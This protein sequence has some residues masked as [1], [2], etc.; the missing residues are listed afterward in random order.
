MVRENRSND[1][2]RRGLWLVDGILARLVTWRRLVLALTGFAAGAVFGAI[3]QDL[4]NSDMRLLDAAVGVLCL[5]I[6]ALVTVLSE[7]SKASRTSHADVIDRLE[8][9]GRYFNLRV[10][11]QM[12]KD[13]NNYHSPDQDLVVQAFRAAKREILVLD[14]LTDEGVRPDIDMNPAVMKWHLDTIEARAREGVAYRRYCQVTDTSKPFH[15]I[16][17]RATTSGGNEH[18]FAD[19][20]IAMCEMRSAA[21]GSVI[22]KVAPHIYP[23]KFVIIDRSVLVLQLHE[24]DSGGSDPDDPRTLCELVVDDPQRQLIDHFTS[25]WQKVDN[26]P[27]TRAI[28]ASDPDLRVL[29]EL[30]G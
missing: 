4:V 17:A 19:H 21:Q 24:V 23:Y 15:H 22:L 11:C 28:T 18:V 30:R 1:T 25:M 16:R 12:L 14:H 2:A 27:H 10:R 5:A 29:R 8:A 6:L 7:V 13:A 26:H 9:F 3:V 20:C